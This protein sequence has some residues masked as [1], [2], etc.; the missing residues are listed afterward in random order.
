M[1][2]KMQKRL[3][4]VFLVFFMF[5]GTTVLANSQ[6]KSLFPEEYRILN[7]CENFVTLFNAASASL[8]ERP[9]YVSFITNVKKVSNPDLPGIIV[10]EGNWG[11]YTTLDIFYDV[12]TENIYSMMLSIPKSYF[13]TSYTNR[14]GYTPGAQY[15][16]SMGM[17][18]G[19]LNSSHDLKEEGRQLFGTLP[20]DFM[21]FDKY[22]Q[23][24]TVGNMLYHYETTDTKIIFTVTSLDNSTISQDTNAL[25]DNSTILKDIDALGYNNNVN[26][27]DLDGLISYPNDSSVQK[28]F[29]SEW[30]STDQLWHDKV[31]ATWMGETISIS[32]DDKNYQRCSIILEGSPKSHFETGKIYESDGIRY[33]Y[34]DKLQDG[35]DTIPINSIC[36]N[37][38]DLKSKGII[39]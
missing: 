31:S 23:D 22:S 38:A 25:A 4:I 34:V 36:F 8:E 14:Y 19:F 28:E 24:Y 13:S 12:E 30:I 16:M 9:E 5:T 29:C 6:R 1:S 11:D 20:E 21:Y 18:S 33:Q 15:F 37:I 3:L 32:Y 35:N 2:M 10:Y 26:S 39:N 17:L 27:R 7:Q